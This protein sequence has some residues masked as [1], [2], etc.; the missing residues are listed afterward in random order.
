MDNNNYDITRNNSYG[1]TET[2]NRGSTQESFSS[3][4]ITTS[5]NSIAPRDN[6]NYIIII[7]KS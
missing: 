5:N 7:Y 3:R 1:L 4:D 2:D 6:S